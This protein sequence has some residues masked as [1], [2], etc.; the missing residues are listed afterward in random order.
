MATWSPPQ[1][2]EFAS[3]RTRP[4][5]DLL[6]QI[7]IVAPRRI[8]DLG[9]GTGNSTALLAER[10]PEAHLDGLD[11]SETMLAEAAKSDITANWLLAD[12]STWIPDQPYDV[13]FSNAA[14]Q[15]LPDQE[16][17]IRR[18]INFISSDG[19]LAFQVPSN[20]GAPSHLIINELAEDIRWR[21]P[22]KGVR[23]IQTGDPAFY[24]DI[25]KTH[26]TPL[27]IWET[28]YLQILSGGDAV[29]R[30]ISGTSLRPFIK[31]LSERDRDTFIVECKSRLALAYPKRSD[32]TT[33]FPFQRIFVV[34]IRN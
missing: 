4:A 34:A 23:R 25:V 17:H 8:I 5:S 24:Y 29:F 30:W 11:S 19:V 13:I 18:F 1:Y 12:M 10:W 20:F 3:E 26:C 33:L 2:L 28:E 21:D 27:T 32:G 7:P 16:R 6:R 31:A 14:F 15:W 9:C 22:L